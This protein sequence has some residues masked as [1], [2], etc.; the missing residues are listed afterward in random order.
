MANYQTNS[1]KYMSD[2]RM[3][4]AGC[5]DNSLR[6]FSFHDN[7]IIKKISAGI[8]DSLSCLEIYRNNYIVAGSQDGSLK[9]WDRRTFK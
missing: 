1:L 6:I 5:E 7:K 2:Y 4:M 9:I 3:I 8:N